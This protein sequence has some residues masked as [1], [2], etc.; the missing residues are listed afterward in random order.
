MQALFIANIP[1]SLLPYPAEKLEEALN[2]VAKH[3]HDL[4]DYNFSK[5]VRDT[6]GPLMLYSDD[7]SALQGAVM[8]FGDP[9]IR[10]S[11][12]S[13]LERAQKRGIQFR[14]AADN[15]RSKA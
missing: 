9:N 1:R 11:I 7:D 4:G 8:K 12:I 14:L 15:S 2:T 10:E 5:L 13:N 6:F 3:Y